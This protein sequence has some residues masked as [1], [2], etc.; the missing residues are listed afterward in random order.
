[1]LRVP[2][3]LMHGSADNITSCKSTSL[4]TRNT[5]KFNTLKIWEGCF[6]ELHHEPN[7]MEVFE[8]IMNWMKDNFKKL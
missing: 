8:Y 6:H 4:F 3:L 1:M 7:R 2:L 5:G